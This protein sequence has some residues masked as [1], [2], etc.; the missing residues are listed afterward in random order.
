MILPREVALRL[1]SGRF[2]REPVAAR[3]PTVTGRPLDAVLV[4]RAAA[5]AA[6]GI[7]HDIEL[8]V[9]TMET[10]PHR[11]LR[12]G[13]VSSRDV[14]AL[15]QSLGT[16]TGHATFV[17]ECAAAA[18]LS[19]PAT[20]TACYPP[21]TTTTGRRGTPR[22]VGCSSRRPGGASA[23]CRSGRANR[24]RTRWARRPKPPGPPRPATCCFD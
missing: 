12:D 15:A 24:A 3:P 11:L 4:D 13:G 17:L 9:Q 20:G 5:G 18:R 7:L 6:F 14:A 19:P 2:T 1:R 23:G 21:P 22:T 10:V 8:A 16:D